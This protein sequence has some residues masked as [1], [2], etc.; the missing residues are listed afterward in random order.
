MQISL[1]KI[2]K[3]RVATSLPI[4]PN[5]K[6]A[7]LATPPSAACMAKALVSGAL[8]TIIAQAVFLSQ[9][10]GLICRVY[11]IVNM[12]PNMTDDHIIVPG[13]NTTL[14]NKVAYNIAFKMETKLL[15]TFLETLP[16]AIRLFELEVSSIP[17]IASK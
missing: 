12:D 6:L 10:M 9:V 17:P 4:P 5:H 15:T 11:K 3:K 8:A 7:L 13:K 16:L 14:I 1:P 2:P